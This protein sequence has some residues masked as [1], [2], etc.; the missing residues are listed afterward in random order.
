MD[1]NL[2]GKVALVTGSTSGIGLGIADRLAAEGCT[3]VVN[4]HMSAA[5]VQDILGDLADKYDDNIDYRPADMSDGTA[6]QR[7][8]A[9]VVKDHDRLDIV[10]NSAGIQ[11]VSPIQ[12]FADSDWENIQDINLNSAFHTT[13][14]AFPGMLEQGWGR[15]IYISSAHGLVASPFKAAYVSAKH[16]MMGLGKVTALE[17]AEHGITCNMIC[18]GYVLTP[19]VEAQIDDQSK[20]HNIPKDEVV[21]EIMLTPQP[22]KKFVQT[23]EIAALAAF[24]CSD[25]AASITGAAIPIDGGWTAR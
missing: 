6:V 13:K 2:T 25:H 7:L 19:L 3:T 1:L 22:T 24:L 21:K 8:V 20:I 9:G 4:S 11:V 15:I 18:P 23:E 12:D 5:E 17:G 16:G 10:V 14:A